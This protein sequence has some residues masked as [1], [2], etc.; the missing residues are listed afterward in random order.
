[1]NLLLEA[2]NVSKSYGAFQ[3]LVNVNMSVHENELISV[4]GPNG[5]GKTTLARAINRFVEAYEALQRDGWAG[6]GARAIAPRGEGT[7]AAS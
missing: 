6:G 3:A 7:H 4:V 5:A 2:R 1:M